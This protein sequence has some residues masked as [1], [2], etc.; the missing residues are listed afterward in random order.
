MKRG[1]LRFGYLMA[2]VAAAISGFSIY[3]NSLGVSVVRDATLYTTL[4]NSVVGL[5]VLVPLVA[6]AGQRAEFARLTRRQWAWLGGLAVIG[7]SVPYVMFFEGLRQTTAVTGSV[8]NHLQ[9]AVVAALA[10]VFLRERLA[11]PI[12]AAL[13]ALLVVS[14][15]GVNLNAFRWGSGA[16][17]VAGSTVL[18]GAGFVIAKHLLRELSTHAVMT[19]KM[20]L[21]SVVLIG[22]SAVT[23]HLAA[24]SHLSAFQWRW[25][26]L[27]GLILFAFTAS[28]LIA[29]KHAPVTS[30]LA[31]GTASPL[32]TLALQTTGGKA[33][34]LVGA[35]AFALA[36]TVAAALLILVWGVWEGRRER[37]RAVA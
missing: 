22:Y 2:V 9:F 12:W 18:F 26:L 34:K 8:L 21:G 24:V 35:P 3:V 10:L 6:L 33:S 28:I 4:K 16:L 17:L 7:G 32:I 23:G 5:I 30:V 20:S 36:V 31:I 1:S 27:T 14:F 29:I 13:V 11:A 37:G 19:A 15:V 25:V